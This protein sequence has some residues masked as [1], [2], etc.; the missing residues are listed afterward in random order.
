MFNLIRFDPLQCLQ[1]KDRK[2]KM[3]M[4][5]SMLIT[6]VG[7]TCHL[8]AGYQCTSVRGDLFQNCLGENNLHA[9]VSGA[10]APSRLTLCASHCMHQLR[11]PAVHFSS[12]SADSAADY[13][14]GQMWCTV[15]SI[16][17]QALF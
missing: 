9:G 15:C 3:M 4:I 5:P 14:S 8:R 16:I 12:V 11:C 13:S 2:D 1:R 10:P 17:L 7:V 6:L